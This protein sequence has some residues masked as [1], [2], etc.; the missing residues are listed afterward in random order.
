[1]GTLRE[2]LEFVTRLSRRQIVFVGEGGTVEFAV[3]PL[4]IHKQLTLH[5][6][7]VTSLP[8]MHDLV[9]FCVR[10]Q[11]HPDVIVTDRFSLA[12]THDAYKLAV[13][14]KCGKVVINPS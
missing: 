10:H 5:G 8:H 3:S 4:L 7:W 14:G 1:M 11:L 2:S 12:E 13:E 9:D 6:S